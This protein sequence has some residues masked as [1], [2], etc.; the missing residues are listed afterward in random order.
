MKKWLAL[1]AVLLNLDAAGAAPP[2]VAHEWGTFTSLQDE[3]GQAI[4]GIN[5]DDEPAPKFV[6]R[7]ADGFFL[8]ASEAP[9]VF[10]QGAPKCHPDVTLR[11]ETPVLYFYPA[12]GWKHEPIDVQVAFR[13]G[14]LTEFY[15]AAEARA[16]GFDAARPDRLF[17]IAPNDDQRTNGFGHLR[18]DASGELSWKGL[19]L[20]SDGTGPETSD[21]VWLAPRAVASTMLR[22]ANGEREKFLFYRGVGH[23]PAALQVVRDLA[24]NVLEIRGPAG[25]SARDA[26]LVDIRADG[27]CAFRSPGVLPATVAAS[28]A[29][30]EF[31]GAGLPRL[32]EE[33][34]SALVR[35]GLFADEA[36]ALLRTW[37][38]SYFKS[39]GLRFFYLCGADEI[40]RLLPLRISAPCDLTRV[41]IGRIEIVTPGQR[42]L[43]AKIS[44]DRDPGLPIPEIDGAYLQLGRFRNALLL[45]E[46]KRRPT[47]ALSDYIAKNDFGAYKIQESSH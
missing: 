5:T 35:A 29:P 17:P 28:F 42:A 20:D 43:L 45:D 6:R 15:P 47:P 27:A 31:S 23:A 8:T 4:G 41:M 44:A 22:T 16:P 37:D 3:A 2:L 46:E 24:R 10:F 7:L 19:E 9:P 33:M 25:D 21:R 13:G 30:E 39:P 1:C 32:Q 40:N 18:A 26:W 11:L 38:V 34:R 36:Q 12:P 14:W